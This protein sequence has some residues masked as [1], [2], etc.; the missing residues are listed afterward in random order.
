MLPSLEIVSYLLVPSSLL[1][2]RLIVSKMFPLPLH[3]ILLTLLF[4]ITLTS[5]LLLLRQ[6]HYLINLCNYM[7]QI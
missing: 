2:L 5:P 3:Y 4:S 6:L 7:F 1:P